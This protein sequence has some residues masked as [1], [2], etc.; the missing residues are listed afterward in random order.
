MTAN[1]LALCKQGLASFACLTVAPCCDAAAFKLSRSAGGALASAAIS[2]ALLSNVVTC[3]IMLHLDQELQ[4]A[5][6]SVKKY[7]NCLLF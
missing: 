4:H 6:T 3:I 5:L 2:S 7:S 1:V